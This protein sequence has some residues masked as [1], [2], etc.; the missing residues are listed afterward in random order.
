MKLQLIAQTQE[1]NKIC[2]PFS[3]LAVFLLTAV[4]AV[5]LVL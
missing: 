3:Q 5:L 4:T 1:Q 2:I